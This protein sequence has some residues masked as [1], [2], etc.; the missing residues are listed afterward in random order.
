MRGTDRDQICL[1]VLQHGLDLGQQVFEVAIAFGLVRRVREIVWVAPKSSA[2]GKAYVYIDGVKVATVTLYR[3][4]SLA[5][6]Q[7]YKKVFSGSGKHTIKI[8]VIDNQSQD[9]FFVAGVPLPSGTRVDI[10]AFQSQPGP[11]VVDTGRHTGRSPKDKVMQELNARVDVD[12]ET[13]R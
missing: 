4:S 5:G 1:R 11:L 8:V 7:I 3:S 2:S 10:G 6:Q 9:P 12:R 13:P